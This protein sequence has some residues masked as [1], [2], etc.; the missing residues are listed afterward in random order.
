M[1]EKERIT[2]EKI[3]MG[4]MPGARGK[5]KGKG[6]EGKDFKWGKTMPKVEE[7]QEATGRKH[8]P[9]MA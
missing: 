1:I 9:Q 6:S 5:S 2:K 8:S 4:K 7:D 3:P